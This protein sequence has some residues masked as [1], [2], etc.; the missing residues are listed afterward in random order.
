[1]ALSLTLAKFYRSNCNFTFYSL[2]HPVH[3]LLRM[4]YDEHKAVVAV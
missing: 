4:D 1:M 2:Q 3:I